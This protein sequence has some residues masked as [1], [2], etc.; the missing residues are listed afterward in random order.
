MGRNMA[1]QWLRAFAAVE[2]MLWHSDLMTKRFSNYSIQT[3]DYAFFGGIGVEV[4]FIVSG[5][6]M[7]LVSSHEPKAWN[8]AIR[9]VIRIY[10][11]YWMFTSLVV[12]AAVISPHWVLGG[13]LARASILESYLIVP[14]NVFPTLMVGWTLEYEIVF[15]CLVMLCLVAATAGPVWKHRWILST[16]LASLGLCGAAIPDAISSSAILDHLLSPYMF[17]F[18]F[19]WLLH[20]LRRHLMDGAVPLAIF[21]TVFAFAFAISSGHDRALM[22]RI[23]IAGVGVVTLMALQPMIGRLGRGGAVLAFAGEASYSIYLSH[24]FVLSILGKVLGVVLPPAVAFDVP[25]RILGCAAAIAAG[26]AIFA[27]VERPLDRWLRDKLLPRKPVPDVPDEPGP[28][29]DPVL[30]PALDGVER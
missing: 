4:F 8:F 10:P 25:A 17:G 27:F 18:G 23:L 14:Q 20:G 3:S 1:I 7:S 2:V 22:A 29:D 26:V 15:Y 19:G 6:L 28:V 9:R 5:F 30:Q 24:W 13:S 16:I 11:L 21:G 12:L